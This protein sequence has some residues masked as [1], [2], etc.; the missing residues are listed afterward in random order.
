MNGKLRPIP[1]SENCQRCKSPLPDS[2]IVAAYESTE[3]NED[4]LV[5]CVCPRC[6]FV[7]TVLLRLQGAAGPGEESIG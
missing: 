5:D 1:G 6:G 7:G 4:K 3:M 2:A